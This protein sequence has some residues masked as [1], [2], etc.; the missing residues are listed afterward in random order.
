M[1]STFGSTH[2]GAP[3]PVPPELLVE[4]LLD[5]VDEPLLEEV[6]PLDVEVVL[7]LEDGGWQ[8]PV[9]HLTSG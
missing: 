6:L 8:Q 4:P 7:L 2:T 9:G 3:P 5:E 1:C